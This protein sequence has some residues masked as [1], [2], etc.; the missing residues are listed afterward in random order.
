[1]TTLHKKL[2]KLNSNGK[3]IQTWEIHCDH[4]YTQYWTVS[5]QVMGKKTVSSPHHVTPKVNRTPQ[6]QVLLEMNAKV[7]LQN[8]KKYVDDIKN[9]GAKADAA[10]P[11]YSAMLAKKWPQQAKHINFPC[12]VQPKLD[13]VRCLATKD[14]FFSRGRKPIESCQHIR[15]ALKPF[16][17]KHPEAQLDGE[18]YTHEFKDDFETIIK[19]VRKSGKRVKPADLELQ[20]KVQYHVY[21]CP[22]IQN[23]DE[24]EPFAVRFGQAIVLL[25]QFGIP[26]SAVVI[27]TTDTVDNGEQL[28][29]AHSSFMHRGYEGTMIRNTVMP[30]E[31]KRSNNLLKMKEFDDDEFEI[32]DVL[33]GRGGLKKHA[34]SFLLKTSNG[35]E[36]RAKLEGSFERLKWIWD[37]PKSVVGKMCT[38]AYQGL[39]NKNN[40]PRFPVAKGIR[41]FKD[42]SDWL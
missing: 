21:D 32:I 13:G 14:G 5:G 26:K 8:R 20:A 2:F 28:V 36:F 41:G 39:T 37:N 33:E 42:R 7:S 23:F 30:Y 10:L 17:D 40:V 6:E 4:A 25:K 38:V 12:T 34:A 31:G 19:A 29:D 22:R 1:M 11:G 18:L 3:T 27:V 35:I 24:T 15:D 9:V 16:F